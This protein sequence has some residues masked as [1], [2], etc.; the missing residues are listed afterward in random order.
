MSEESIFIPQEDIDMAALAGEI[1]ALIVLFICFLLVP[2]ITAMLKSSLDTLP[3][4]LAAVILIL[5]S[6][7]YDRYLALG[8]LLVVTAVYIQHHHEDILDIVGTAN[9]MNAFD[10]SSNKKHN[11][12]MQQ[13][14]QGGNA[15]ETYETGDF[16]SKTEDQNNEFNPVDSTMNEKHVLTTEPLGSKSQNLFPEDSRHVNAMERGNT[17]G[18]SD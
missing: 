2:Q 3:M 10:S 5:G 12:T 1:A 18:Y 11:S 4:R 13:L 6:V 16:T 7:S 17:N 9:N 8:T 15:D 14:D